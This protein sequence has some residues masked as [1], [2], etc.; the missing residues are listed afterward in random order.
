MISL[1][2]LLKLHIFRQPF[3]RQENH[4]DAILQIDLTTVVLNCN[5]LPSRTVRFAETF[6]TDDLNFLVIEWISFSKN[7]FGES[8]TI[9]RVKKHRL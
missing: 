3:K 8:A 2:Q 7:D 6:Q 9:R 1:A 5:G 4:P